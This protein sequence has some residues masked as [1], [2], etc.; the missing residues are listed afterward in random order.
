M[1]GAS[2]AHGTEAARDRAARQRRGE[3][4]SPDRRFDQRHR[5]ASTCA[6]STRRLP[7][8]ATTTASPYAPAGRR[9]GPLHLG[10]FHP[11]AADVEL[12]V[13]AADELHHVRRAPGPEIPGPVPAAPVAHHETL[14]SSPP[15][16]PR[17]RLVDGRPGDHEQFARGRPSGDGS[18]MPCRRPAS[19][20]PGIGPP[21]GTHPSLGAEPVSRRPDGR[22]GRPVL[23]HE[24]GAGRC[25]ATCSRDH[26]RRGT[27]RRRRSRRAEPRETVGAASRAAP[28]S[29]LGTISVCETSRA[30]R[31]TP[32]ARSTSCTSVS[33]SG[34]TIGAARRQRPE[35]TD[36]RAV[37]PDAR[38]HAG[39]GRA[40]GRTTCDLSRRCSPRGWRGTPPPR[41]ADRST[42]T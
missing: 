25:T 40:R 37:E 3:L 27:P 14:R 1:S 38:G 32:R 8:T 21:I 35:Q 10:R 2:S 24:R 36:H 30:R 7:L 13:D 20:T 41:A 11:D 33:S 29:R 42:R 16:R 4:G 22:L 31:S 17:S 18:P 39:T 15:R 19:Q 34:I 12:V 28:G 9:S 6:T 23:V 5:S 26:L